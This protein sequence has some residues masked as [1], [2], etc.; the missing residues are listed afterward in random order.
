[1]PHR[2]Q[3]SIRLWVSNSA[4]ADVYKRQVLALA[5]CS[6]RNIS[7]LAAFAAFGVGAAALGM[8]Y[9]RASWVGMACA[10]VVMVFLWK[11][12]LI[13]A[14]AALCIVC[15][16]LLPD[17]IWNRILTI[18]NPKDTSTASRLPLYKACLL[19]TSAAA[20]RKV[21]GRKYVSASWN[22]LR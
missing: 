13:P 1:M 19:Y 12:K 9:S 2:G 16:P 18:T 17:T 22:G 6:K 14:F 3:R 7:K 8:T 5:L 11:P 15:I 10:M 21:S 4:E 20:E